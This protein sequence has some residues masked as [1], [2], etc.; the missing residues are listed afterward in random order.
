M[1]TS[2]SSDALTSE[3]G[4]GSGSEEETRGAGA[5]ED[6]STGVTQENGATLGIVAEDD[7]YWSFQG[8][9]LVV[10]PSSGLLANDRSSAEST[11]VASVV[12][13]RTEAGGSVA[14][15]PDGSFTYSPPSDDFWG[16]DSFRY[17]AV[18]DDEEAVAARARVMVAPR[19]IST[20][21]LSLGSG[22]RLW[23]G[24][25]DNDRFGYALS[26]VG[27]VDGDGFEEILVGAYN[28]G[29]TVAGR[30]YLIY[31]S[32]DDVSSPIGIP[33]E[34]SDTTVL[35]GRANRDRFGRAVSAAGDVN[36][37]GFDDFIIGAYRV[38]VGGV[39]AAGEAY[40]V[41]G[42]PGLSR[43]ETYIV[44][45]VINEGQGVILAGSSGR[46]GA[47]VSGGA[48][49]NGDGFDDV[50][51]GAYG[52]GGVNG[53]AAGRVYVVLGDRDGASAGP[54]TLDSI[55]EDDR[56]FMI[57]GP[58]AGARAGYSVAGIGDFNGDF[59]DDIVVFGDRAGPNGTGQ[60]YIVF[61]K[62]DDYS[63]DLSRVG[64]IPEAI[65]LGLGSEEQVIGAGPAGDVN[66]D[67]LSDIVAVSWNAY[68]YVI[69]GRRDTGMESI[70]LNDILSGQG[71]FAVESDALVGIRV[72]GGG[73]I[74]GD[75]FDDVIVGYAS[76]DGGIG[77]V[78]V[79]Y[80]SSE[81]RSS[82]MM[83]SQLVDGIHGFTI[84]GQYREALGSSVGFADVNNDG[85]ADL[86]IGANFAAA[87]DDSHPG[88][89]YV[90]FGGDFRRRSLR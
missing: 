35:E 46:A 49:V 90:M 34:A 44:D 8:E 56:G 17:M 50:I 7:E 88:G 54:I 45:R 1:S 42:G 32:A 16:E 36:G 3:S 81:P 84:H 6:S 85:L 68:A 43:G 25:G 41:Y 74:D 83:T 9:T 73:D 40:V 38:D 15:L 22:G 53:D 27:D 59:R 86:L 33:S 11:L 30:A 5:L 26:G 71:G 64:F 19:E 72:A 51:V 37:D 89:A 28:A 47:S 87:A 13:A 31:G 80:G 24:E 23:L 61:G 48:D 82:P 66:G 39:T 12:S 65:E 29:G 77:R 57:E 63:I 21:P 52:Y 70:P 4:I 14:V 75:G 20:V 69:Y 78:T 2:S 62:G 10:T 79:V 67:G 18:S 58:A 76:A 55:E 60:C